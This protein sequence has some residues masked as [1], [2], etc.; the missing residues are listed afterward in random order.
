MDNHPAIPYPHPLPT[1]T[2]RRQ[3]LCSSILGLAAA[4]LVAKALS[5]PTTSTGWVGDSGGVGV[6]GPAYVLGLAIKVP[7]NRFVVERYRNLRP[8][9]IT[10][11]RL[12]FVR[13]PDEVRYEGVWDGTFKLERGCSNPAYILADLYERTGA[14]PD[15]AL[16][17][18]PSISPFAP[19]VMGGMYKLLKP[20]LDWEMLYAWGVWADE[21]TEQWVQ[22][23]GDFRPLGWATR[24]TVNTLCATHEDMVQLRETLRMHCLSWQATDE[25]YRTSWPGIEHPLS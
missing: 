11:G 24:F 7:S 15:W 14:E 10:L 2:T 18:R 9:Q 16:A 3:F 23:E 17:V 20:R 21:L 22:C 8:G 6:A 19:M 4:P 1:M 25:R 12:P 13:D 5:A